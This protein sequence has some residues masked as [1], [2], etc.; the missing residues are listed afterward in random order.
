MLY[1]HVPFLWVKMPRWSIDLILDEAPGV[2][3][4]NHVQANRRI[5]NWNGS[6]NCYGFVLQ[7]CDVRTTEEMKLSTRIKVELNRQ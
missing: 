1:T 3:Q 4:E 6:S 2:E 5:S 7:E